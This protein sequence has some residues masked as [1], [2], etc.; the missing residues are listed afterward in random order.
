MAFDEYDIYLNL[1]SLIRGRG[2]TLNSKELEPKEFRETINNNKLVTLKA[3][4]TLPESILN[5]QNNEEGQ[6][7][8]SAKNH[9]ARIELTIILLEMNAKY[10]SS[11][12]QF[13]KLLKTV[14]LGDLTNA[15]VL[16]V[17]EKSP[18]KSV[19]EAIDKM[20][21]NNKGLLF[22]IE[23]NQK[24]VLNMLNHNFRAEILSEKSFKAENAP[25]AVNRHDLPYMRLNDTLAIWT[26]AR[27]GDIIKVYRPSSNTGMTVSYRRII[28]EMMD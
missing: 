1:L 9:P 28:P 5:W 26:G 20:M 14:S 3:G 23:H 13:T 7:G 10:V 4:G 18:H 24:F 15:E 11:N 22:R 12:E 6:S 21:G 16:I 25:F 8:T 17:T 2:F 27:P 19:R